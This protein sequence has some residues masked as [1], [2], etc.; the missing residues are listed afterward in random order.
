MPNFEAQLQRF[1]DAYGVTTPEAL[2]ERMDMDKYSL[3]AWRRLKRI[4]PR[5]LLDL[6]QT[7][8]IR[9]AYILTGRGRKQVTPDRLT[10]NLPE[11]GEAL[12]DLFEQLSAEQRQ[13][14]LEYARVL[15]HGVPGWGVGLTQTIHEFATLLQINHD[16]DV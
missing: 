4:P 9:R 15:R 2:A 11:P 13:S 14:L 7:K 10:K 1:M 3:S 6:E 5:R 16:L 12:V 8:G